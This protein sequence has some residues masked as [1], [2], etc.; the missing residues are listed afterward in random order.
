M[1]TVAKVR[2]TTANTPSNHIVKRRTASDAAITCSMS[3][4]FENAAVRETAP[5]RVLHVR[6]H[7]LRTPRGKHDQHHAVIPQPLGF[8]EVELQS[9]R[10]IESG[11]KHVSDDAD[12]RSPR[13]I[14][15]S[16]F[17]PL[18]DRI[19]TR[20]HAPSQRLVDQHD[21]LRFLA[22][23]IGEAAA[24]TNWNSHYSQVAG[25]DECSG[26]RSDRFLD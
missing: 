15:P 1:P 11:M 18:A 26:H 19:F 9:V 14:Q 7:G 3:A 24:A 20:P 6:D 8:G 25:A 23:L 13:T 5:A 16:N 22:V 12:Y 21:R 2:A 10:S 17:Q 4:G